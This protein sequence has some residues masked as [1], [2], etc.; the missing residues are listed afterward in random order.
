MNEEN[1]LN[2]GVTIDET[3]VENE[4]NEQVNVEKSKEEF[5]ELSSVSSATSEEESKVNKAKKR[6]IVIGSVVV[7]LAIVVGSALLIRHSV[8]SNTQIK[9]TISLINNIGTIEYSEDCK[10][11]IDQAQSNYDSLTDKQKNKID[12][13][14][15]LSN[16][17]DEYAILEYKENLISASN[18]M[19]TC[20]FYAE[21]LIGDIYT[22]WHNA[23]F[24][25]YDK[26]NKGNY[27]FNAAIQAYYKDPSNAESIKNYKTINIAELDSLIKKLQN[28]PE[29]YKEAYNAFINAYGTFSRV[30][31]L[32]IMATGTLKTYS[33]QSNELFNTFATQYGVLK[34]HLPEITGSSSSIMSTLR[35]ALS[36]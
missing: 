20:E 34:A 15:V 27:D 33:E 3:P 21:Y 6:L 30:Y 4:I 10:T 22:A 26:Y 28:P 11:R 2:N 24:S 23:V 9:D 12:N 8:I 13:Y 7:A 17:T 32:A 5:V 35:D 1:N 19:S 36:K 31:E 18:R 16:A 29:E 14:K 25:K